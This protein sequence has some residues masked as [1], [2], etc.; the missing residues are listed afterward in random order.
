MY[1]LSTYFTIGNYEDTYIN[2]GDHI[3]SSLSPLLHRR[4]TTHSIKKR[5]KV[6]YSKRGIAMKKG[7]LEDGLYPEEI[8]ALERIDSGKVKMVTYDSAK[9]FLEQMHKELGLEDKD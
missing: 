4:P 3:T 5:V 6:R 7:Q 1:L 2:N 9:D 8:R